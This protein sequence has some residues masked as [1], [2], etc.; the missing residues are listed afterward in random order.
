MLRHSKDLMNADEAKF[1][2]AG[3]N[4]GFQSKSNGNLHLQ[5]NSMAI[6]YKTGAVKR[7]GC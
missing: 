1:K 4:L 3:K 2:H 5:N 7:L 6:V